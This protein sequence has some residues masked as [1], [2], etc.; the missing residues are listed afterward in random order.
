MWRKWEEGL[1]GHQA[2]QVSPGARILCTVTMKL[3]PVRMEEKPTVNTAN[4]A[5]TTALLE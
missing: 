3:S 2:K 1:N 5:N 4:T